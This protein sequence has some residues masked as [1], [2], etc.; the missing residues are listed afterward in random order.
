MPAVH[1]KPKRSH[2]SRSKAEWYE[3]CTLFDQRPN[4]KESKEQFCNRMKV[5]PSTF[6]TNYRKF[7][8]GELQQHSDVKRLRARKFEHLEDRMIKYIELREKRYQQDKCGLSWLLMREK[9]LDWAET[10]GDDAEFKCSPGWISS[11][12]KRGGKVS[13]KLHGEGQEMTAGDAAKAMEN[14][15][16]ELAT[17]LRE[18]NSVPICVLIAEIICC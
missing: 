9:V 7:S 8:K 15:R 17:F 5:S 12:L 10:T 14:F 18:G 1:S 11:A 2:E 4:A 3:L 16:R 13:V 6:V